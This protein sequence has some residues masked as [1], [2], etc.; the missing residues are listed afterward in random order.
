MRRGRGELL[1]VEGEE[2]SGKS[3]LLLRSGLKSEA[4]LDFQ[5]SFVR[6]GF[7]PDGVEVQA[8]SELYRQILDIVQRAGSASSPDE[9]NPWLQSF[10]ELLDLAP[11]RQ[12]RSSGESAEQVP[13]G[14]ARER[15]LDAALR[16]LEAAASCKTLVLVLEDIQHAGELSLALLS[17]V[18]RR[19]SSL[20]VLLIVS[21][22]P[23]AARQVSGAKR[24]LDEVD[25]LEANPRPLRLGGLPDHELAAFLDA[26]LTPAATISSSLV[27]YLREQT[28]GVPLA[29]RRWLVFLWERGTLVLENGRWTLSQT[30]AD[31]TAPERWSERLAALD[32]HVRELLVAAAVFGSRFELDWLPRLA[33]PDDPDGLGAAGRSLRAL[34]EAGF[35]VETPDGFN[36]SSDFDTELLSPWLAEERQKEL[37]R[38]AAEFLRSRDPRGAGRQPL[39]L[40]R[41]YEI[42]GNRQA[43]SRF[44]S[45]AGRQAARVHA[46]RLG[47]D[48]FRR[49]LDLSEEPRGRARIAEELGDLHAHIGQYAEA[50]AAFEIAERE[51]SAS[52]PG[53]MPIARRAEL[54]DKIGRVLH[55]QRE[56]ARAQ[57]FFERCAQP[58]E[59]G[60]KDSLERL[61]RAHVRLAGVHFDR[62]ELRAARDLYGRS[63]KFYGASGA[64][65]NLI[66]VYSGLGLVEK[67]EN[68]I[69]AAVG[70][71]EKALA[72]A[73][74]AGHLLEAAAI[75][76]NLG[77]L[78]RARGEPERAVDCLQSSIETRERVGDRRGLAICLNNM[79]QIH[80]QGGELEAA[81]SATARSLSIFE[82]IGDQKG[83]L[84]SECNLGE[85][86][87]LS[88][89]IEAS[90]RA[91]EKSLTRT[92]RHGATRLQ[93]STLFHLA[94][95][96]LA[97]GE[98]GR[99]E[100]HLRRCLKTLPRG[101]LHV[102]RRRT[103]T[104]LA[105]ALL[106]LSRMEDAEDCL[107]EA[108]HLASTSASTENIAEL[109]CANVQLHLARGELVEAKDSGLRCLENKDV[110][111]DRY[112]LARLHLQLGKT[113]RDLGPDWADH[114]EKH[115]GQALRAFEGMGCPHEAAETLAQLGIYW[116]FVGEMETA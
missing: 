115:F 114:T 84:I 58:A 112:G 47:I 61:A 108:Y 9:R 87:L 113:F 74:A 105:E 37:H 81:R 21:Y 27:R 48:S 92:A 11:D 85:L 22:R 20:P 10:L 12:T 71:F 15:F 77:N 69:D 44:H 56:L 59:D 82:E 19:L 29:L 38:R 28:D 16:L 91:L 6:G 39:R 64:P 100:D 106:A 104:I 45:E 98:P 110:A 95:A 50:V 73:R 65:E 107:R 30:P 109:H 24:W 13:P 34:V 40:A 79:A 33:A 66:P 8:L 54:W 62:G 5:A 4:L 41:H 67:L 63:L 83:V 7:S 36:L 51:G 35:L 99:A 89:R 86:L 31:L 57:E 68:R 55:R 42:A 53:G 103:L 2:G 90:R 52:A 43:A 49:A 111:V 101:E 76:N 17:R 96:D 116:S 14:V 32:P 60:K 75:L 80:L 3:W 18:V 88:G 26:V 102:L 97:L 70:W 46:H 25:E 78:C 72:A 93:G 94:R 23:G 1:R